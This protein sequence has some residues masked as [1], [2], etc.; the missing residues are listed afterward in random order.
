[1]VEGS[2]SKSSFASH[3][4]FNES[5]TCNGGFLENVDVAFGSV[6]VCRRTRAVPQQGPLINFSI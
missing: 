6:P 4:F 1:M 2:R 3:S 5:R